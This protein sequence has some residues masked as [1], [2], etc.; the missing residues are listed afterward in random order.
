M[1]YLEHA[2]LTVP[3]IDAA[4][5]FL[6]TIDPQIEVWHDETPIGSYRWAHVGIGDSYIALQE[7]HLGI[8]PENNRRPYKDFGINHL[9]WV[10]T[11][12]DTVVARLE[13]ADY[14]KGIP[15]EEHRFR[16]RV[17]YYDHAGLE[18][19]LIEYRTE[20]REERFSYE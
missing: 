8:Q 12:L 18:W 15:G 6:K 1:T 11:D 17:Y 14:R 2:N 19:E 20:R 16:R 10:V 5:E 13:A 9:G 4:I 7:P 3:D